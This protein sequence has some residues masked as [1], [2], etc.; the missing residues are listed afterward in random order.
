MNEPF[1]GQRLEFPDGDIAVVIRIEEYKDEE[2]D[3]GIYDA[4]QVTFIIEG[5]VDRQEFTENLDSRDGYK[6]PIMKPLP[7]PSPSPHQFHKL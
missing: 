1:I 5:D 6:Y 3:L 2:D 7:C 4:K